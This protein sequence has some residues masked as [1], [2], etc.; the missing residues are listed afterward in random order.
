M[1]PGILVIPYMVRIDFAG[2][3]L[4]PSSSH[5]AM[6]LFFSTEDHSSCQ[7]YVLLKPPLA[8]PYPSKP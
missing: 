6:P 5:T 2:W 7:A 3:V 1:W 4:S 8:E